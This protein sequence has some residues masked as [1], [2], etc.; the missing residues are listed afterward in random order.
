MVDRTQSARRPARQASRPPTARPS[1]TSLPVARCCRTV[2]GD[3]GRASFAARIP[4]CQCGFMVLAH[5]RLADRTGWKFF[6]SQPPTSLSCAAITYLRR[7]CLPRRLRPGSHAVEVGCS[8][9]SVVQA[10]TGRPIP[11]KTRLDAS[12]SGSWSGSA[13]ARSMTLC[14]AVD[15]RSGFAGHHGVLNK[16][17]TPGARADKNLEVLVVSYAVAT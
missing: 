5:R 9:T 8:T 10:S 12:T 1:P 16:M 13:A 3:C 14:D 6:A 15:E 17:E 7:R 11:P 4:L 2:A